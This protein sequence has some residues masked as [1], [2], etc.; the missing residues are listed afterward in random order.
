MKRATLARVRTVFVIVSVLVLIWSGLLGP[1]ASAF[2]PDET[3]DRPDIDWSDYANIGTGDGGE[4][5]GV[6]SAPR[7]ISTRGMPVASAAPDG[8]GAST[9]TP[10]SAPAVR[11]GDSDGN[12]GG[13]EIISIGEAQWT[14]SPKEPEVHLAD[15]P[16]T[17]SMESGAEP[18][19]ATEPEAGEE[20]P[21]LPGPEAPEA[22]E[23]GTVTDIVEPERVEAPSLH[24]DERLPATPAN[25]NLVISEFV[26]WSGAGLQGEW[27]EIYNPT[28]SPILLDNWHITGTVQILQWDFPVSGYSVPAYGYCTVAYDETM[29]D[30]MYGFS[31]TFAVTNNILSILMTDSSMIPGLSE[32]DN[33]GDQIVLW[34]NTFS[35]IDAAEYNFGGFPAN[36]VS[37]PD[38]ALARWSTYLDRDMSNI[39]LY[40]ETFPNTPE[41]PNSQEIPA[42]VNF[43][44]N[45]RTRDTDGDGLYDDLMIDFNITVNTAGNYYLT[46]YL[47][48]SA[49]AQLDNAN[50]YYYYDPGNYTRTLYFNGDD[51]FI[52]FSNDTYY[53]EDAQLYAVDMGWLTIGYQANPYTFGFYNYDDFD[54]PNAYFTG[55]YGDYGY[56]GGDAGILY[57]SLNWT[58]EVEIGVPGTYTIESYLYTGGGSFVMRDIQATY[59]LASGP[60]W[61]ELPF[62]G[63][64]IYA[65]GYNGSFD[66]RYLSIKDAYVGSTHHYIDTVAD[67]TDV[68]YNYDDFDPPA[69]TLDDTYYD[70]GED[71]GGNPEYEYLT[72]GVNVTP[73]LP[74]TNYR[75]EAE[76]DTNTNNYVTSAQVEFSTGFVT[77]SRTEYL[78]FPGT[79]IYNKGFNGSYRVRYVKVFRGDRME[80]YRDGTAYTTG[81]YDYTEFEAP[82]SDA[83]I[84]DHLL[85]VYAEG[86]TDADANGLWDSLDFYVKV[87][88]YT[89]QNYKV[90]ATLHMDVAPWDN[91]TWGE[92]NWR[93]MSDGNEEWLKLSFS[94]RAINEFGYTGTFRVRNLYLWDMNTQS[95]QDSDTGNVY[96]MGWYDHT[97]FEPPITPPSFEPISSWWGGGSSWWC[98]VEGYAEPDS[99][100]EL[101]DWDAYTGWATWVN[102]TGYFSFGGYYLGDSEHNLSARCRVGSDWSKLG[103]GM[104]V[105]MVMAGAGGTVTSSDGRASVSIRPNALASDTPISVQA[106]ASPAVPGGIGTF[107]STYDFGPHFT[108]FSTPAEM[109][110]SYEDAWL[111]GTP[112]SRIGIMYHDG[113]NW[114]WV[115]GDVDAGVNTI[116]VK[117]EHFTPFTGGTMDVFGQNVGPSTAAR[118]DANV[119][120]LALQFINSGPL[121]NIL[122]VVVTSGN[123][124]DNDVIQATIWEDDG[125][126]VFNAG[127]DTPWGVQPFVAGQAVFGG[128][129]IPVPPGPPKYVFISYDVAP[130]ATFG[131]QLDCW[132]NVNDI[133]LMIGGTNTGVIDPAGGTIVSPLKFTGVYN[134]YP[135]DG[136]A[137]GLWE[138]LVYEMEVNASIPG[139]YNV[140]AE[141]YHNMAGNPSG[142]FAYN[143]TYLYTG[144]NTVRLE[145]WGLPLR[146]YLDGWLPVPNRNSSWE[147]MDVTITNQTI[148]TVMAYDATT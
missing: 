140:T 6:D 50:S 98:D 103:P 17:R 2:A 110:I 51:I 99:W 58:I 131:N 122:N 30:S 79:D 44:D 13:A 123:D 113:G 83:Y 3:V 118:G 36:P 66:L 81:S 11:L 9:G 97:T 116:T 106:V 57:D 49:S 31:P 84:M 38:N 111:S 132:V 120:I 20:Q 143:E 7:V 127:L 54:P 125:D 61:V 71:T 64:L 129:N 114:V 92:S 28:A 88:S 100:V 95:I 102:G 77:G 141:L 18:E 85:D 101:W 96:T 52:G 91:I 68:T 135:V 124:D 55:N 60:Q 82:A 108:A 134:H 121:D 32:F 78:Q 147:L 74:L 137:N 112:E 46:A 56:D 109:T 63:A 146:Q 23:A 69:A 130:G 21:S 75:I 62:P 117:V 105:K 33:G 41:A 15:G 76:L 59:E 8:N 4:Y 145:Y 87:H 45:E 24:V 70:Y 65:E 40:E 29:F 47:R 22:V 107:G 35:T 37:M 48:D 126:T 136:D 148:M 86:R 10:A 26:Y 27:L 14:G 90:T 138:W 80:D 94:G 142:F 139:N 12:S 1:L 67:T 43:Y 72:V 128:L 133:T 119:P 73:T 144:L 104:R 93:W 39:D 42:I 115:G 89:S 19:T 34:D 16:G 25:D 5:G 53:L